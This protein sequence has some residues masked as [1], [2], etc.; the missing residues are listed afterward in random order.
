MIN[1]LLNF[2]QKI[3]FEVIVFAFAF[4]VRIWRLSK[5]SLWLDEAFSVWVASHPI[6]EI[7]QILRTDAHPPLF[8]LL[9]HFWLRFGRTEVFLRLPFVLISSFNAALIYKIGKKCFDKKTALLTS[10][11]WTVSVVALN[12]ETQIRMYGMA[13]CAALA[14]TWYFLNALQKPVLLNRI[15]YGVAAS[16]CLYTHY[17]TGFILLTHLLFLTARKRIKEALR[18]FL[19]FAIVFLPWLNILFYQIG[20]GVSKKMLTPGWSALWQIVLH[21]QGIDIFFKGSAQDALFLSAGLLATGY[22]FFLIIAKKE[23]ASNKALIALLFLIPFLLPFGISRFSPYHIFIFRYAIIFA[24]YFFLLFFYAL[25]RTPKILFILYAAII[26]LINSATWILLMTG[27]AYDRQNWREASRFLQKHLTYQDVVFVEQ[28]M[29]LYPLWYY[30][31]DYFHILYLPLNETTA[32]SDKGGIAWIGVEKDMRSAVF[33]MICNSSRR[34]W[35]VLNQAIEEDPSL[36][37]LHW[38]NRHQ[39]PTI[40]KIYNSSENSQKIYIYLYQSKNRKK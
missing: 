34:Q 30:M 37:I 9:L 23:A 17:Y 12:A 33:Q 2:T 26:V 7:L 1:R 22:A 16:L 40:F 35:L 19:F 32:V 8:Y 5:Q 27:K 14:A 4:A 21:F 31:Q 15:K 10:A 29:A 28:G 20:W 6:R 18:L 39:K 24:P 38:L 13:A 36:K 11:F 25:S 3:P